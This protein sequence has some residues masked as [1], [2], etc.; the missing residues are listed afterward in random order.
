M[1]EDPA[2]P[3][4]PLVR[5]ETLRLEIS[6]FRVL[7]GK[8]PL[9]AIEVLHPEV[10]LRWDE[11]GQL[12]LRSPLRTHAPQKPTRPSRAPPVRL[13][14]LSLYFHE[15]PH[16]IRDGARLDLDQLEL[17]IA[18]RIG[19]PEVRTFRL[20]VADD[21][22]LG[23]LT[24]E[25]EAGPDGVQLALHREGLEVTRALREFLRPELG[26]LLGRLELGGQIELD[27]KAR[28]PAGGGA[29]RWQSQ[30]RL[31]GASA[32]VAPWPWPIE[33]L[34][35]VIDV[36]DGA[37][38]GRGLTAR[39]ER[40]RLLVDLDVEP[41]AEG[42]H[43]S[44]RGEVAGL[45]LDE[46]FLSGIDPQKNPS[47]PHPGPVV[48]EQLQRFKVRGPIAVRYRF[49][50]PERP[51][52]HA[53]ELI[54]LIEV[55]LLNTRFA[56]LGEPDGRGGRQNAFPY[57]VQ[58]LQG[59]IFIDH[60]GLLTRGVRTTGQS[61]DIGVHAVVDYRRARDERYAVLVRGEGV[62]L[63]DELYDAM[64]PGMRELVEGLKP[65]GPLG[66]GLTVARA[67]GE[68]L[69]QPADVMVRLK[70]NTLDPE[71]FPLSFTRVRGT[72]RGGRGVVHLEDVRGE[73]LGVPWT[74]SGTVSSLARDR[75]LDL[76]GTARDVPLNEE[77]LRALDVPLPEVAAACRRLAPTGT[78]DRVQLR[79]L[80]DAR[81][82]LEISGRLELLGLTLTPQDLGITLEDV[83]L[84]LDLVPTAEGRTEVRVAKGSRARCAGVLCALEG[85]L[86][87]G[88]RFILRARAE[89]VRVDASTLDGLAG[90]VPD[91]ADRATRPAL[92]GTATVRLTLAGTEFDALGWDLGLDFREASLV[93]D[94]ASPWRLARARGRLQIADQ[95][96][97]RVFDLTGRL[98]ERDTPPTAQAPVVRV[99]RVDV[100]P[101]EE[102]ASTWV[103]T[104]LA[105]REAPLEKWVLESL[106]LVRPSTA[107][108]PMD[109]RLDATFGRVVL[110]PGD[111]SPRLEKGEV[112]LHEAR[113]GE[114]GD[115]YVR[116][117]TL[118]DARAS[119]ERPG[120]WF[121]RA[122]LAGE[123]ASLLS[124]PLPRFEGDLLA[125]RDGLSLTGL[126]GVLF[127]TVP[128]SE[129]PDHAPR[130]ALE[131][132]AVR[133]GYLDR[134]RAARATREELVAEVAR[135]ER[136]DLVRA[137]EDALRGFARARAL[138]GPRV[139]ESL[140]RRGLQELIEQRG[141]LVHHGQID[142][143]SW[144]QVDFD[145]E[146][147]ET[148][149]VLTPVALRPV[150]ESLVGMREGPDGRFRSR[151]TLRGTI[152]SWDTLSG[153]GSVA[154]TLE[155]LVRVPAFFEMVRALD[156]GSWFEASRWSRIE[157]AFQLD[158]QGLSVHEAILRGRGITMRL[159]ET[160]R[161][162]Y[163]GSVALKLAIAHRSGV[164]LISHLVTLI[165]NLVFKQAKISG[166]LADPVVE[167][168]SG[169]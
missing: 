26:D 34:Q 154:A 140:D 103:L 139:L 158:A 96:P 159:A 51:R 50:T 87:E 108:P 67:P 130:E 99:A 28:F 112:V 6:L 135:H 8:S 41:R 7:A 65:G 23:R 148:E 18:S 55:D 46:T 56:Y 69:H 98:A 12:D 11:L 47:F 13:R 86:V 162:D 33:D 165:P 131:D 54:P 88:R 2:R 31:A 123:E 60:E 127:G 43:V 44:V 147:F 76:A 90:L 115:L 32:R 163:D 95:T 58:G 126:S 70:D 122:R 97:L 37:F 25:G 64:P 73:A 167:I 153:E 89:D 85:S 72:A 68:S 79:F 155:D 3:G 156:L 141:H 100:V 161:V 83:D 48:F 152:G 1:V 22:V 94:P 125:N 144:L 62:E 114:E 160:G 117:L 149:L 14:G 77:L 17:L 45:V 42:Q 63:D 5:V 136:I 61:H 107:L 21:P 168:G 111:G 157:A 30:L 133:R 118:A 20:E 81:G 15:P 138:A 101:D 24:A 49:F 80:R 129:L 93:L 35:G 105:V 166:T 10:H 120:E 104:D 132:H 59:T 134:E 137:S 128:R 124:V 84:Y 109:G 36:E 29:P 71:G 151:L 40:G 9:A 110:P 91:F 82:R 169:S 164:P 116:R 66:I 142:G 106:R 92:E 121:V 16:T 119:E 39:M 75:S 53:P 19:Q 145:R 57:E 52:R 78:I 150:L 143:A 113:I 27:A 4:Q 102:G 74:V 146:T 38:R